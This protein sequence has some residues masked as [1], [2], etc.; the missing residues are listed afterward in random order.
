MQ[1]LQ[2][3]LAIAIAGFL[4]CASQQDTVRP[5]AVGPADVSSSTREDEIEGRTI[6]VSGVVRH[7]DG[8]PAEGAS[9]QLYLLDA[10]ADSTGRFR[11]EVPW[12]GPFTRMVEEG[13]HVPLCAGLPGFQPALIHEFE[14]R[15]A[16]WEDIWGVELV[17]PGPALSISGR[18]VGAGRLWE[19]E[20][21]D[22]TEIVPRVMPIHYAEHLS[23][24]RSP[25]QL[26]P[27]QVSRD[28]TFTIDGLLPRTYVVEGW[29]PWGAPVMVRSGPVAAGT[30]D[31][32]LR[33]PSGARRNLRG[34][35]VD[36]K[37]RPFS[38]LSLT[39]WLDIRVSF[40]R[41]HNSIEVPET[42][43]DT[44]GR[45]DFL[46]PAT[47]SSLII[48]GD[49]I[50]PCRIPIE[51]LLGV[52]DLVLPVARRAHFAFE[53]A[54]RG[55]PSPDALEVLDD[56]GARLGI[57]VYEMGR[58]RGSSERYALK[59]PMTPP[60]TVSETARTVVVLHGG[61]VLDRL[62][63]KLTPGQTVSV[64]VQPQ[65]SVTPPQ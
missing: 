9:I 44:D 4:A 5:R 20:L 15:V 12:R 52:D 41:H 40:Q 14:Q 22:G 63:V 56:E 42:T 27:I 49:D 26:S 64:V 39:V 11:F 25:T 46:V 37:G 62:P 17:L 60:L 61:R 23:S 38:G 34:R 6:E 19:V 36:L 35:V 47:F 8:S 33:I 16:A 53:A 30:D 32:V 18:I 55:E 43:T 65:G 54:P 51:G 1:V 3:S 50:V 7:R 28:G 59:G 57:Y 31:L 24:A 29:L 2:R 45:F 48:T 58:F 13:R 10:K 21:R